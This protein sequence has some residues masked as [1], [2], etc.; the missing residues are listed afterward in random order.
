MVLLFARKII[1]LSRCRDISLFSHVVSDGLNKYH[2]HKAHQVGQKGISWSLV[3][4]K[5]RKCLLFGQSKRLER[6]G[7]AVRAAV[8]FLCA[9]NMHTVNCHSS[10]NLYGNTWVS[11]NVSKWHWLCPP[12][13]TKGHRW[14]LPEVLVRERPKNVWVVLWEPSAPSSLVKPLY[15]HAGYWGPPPWHPSDRKA[16]HRIIQG[17]F[18]PLSRVWR[19][20]QR[21][22]DV[23]QPVH[24]VVAPVLELF[25]G[26]DRCPARQH[27]QPASSKP[28]QG[29]GTSQIFAVSPVA[30]SVEELGS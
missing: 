22:L 16:F 28:M 15:L 19:S 21:Q 29:S 1:I 8:L 20:Q 30:P 26:K 13:L 25:W 9:S 5:F 24:C 6:R 18:R 17:C 12:V 27:G 7:R 3:D 23:Q 2:L 10:Q 14:Q 11:L 4:V